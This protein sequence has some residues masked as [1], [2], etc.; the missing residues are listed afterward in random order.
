MELPGRLVLLGHPVAQSLSPTFQN[1]ALERAGIALVYEA[2]DVAPAELPQ[3]LGLLR[4]A[5]GAGNVTVPHKQAVAAQCARRSPV[6][7]RAGA[8]N[9]FWTE[10]GELIGDNTDVG[11]FDR[12][13]RET[14]GRP[15]DGTHLL[16]LGAG[17]AASAVLTAAERWGGARVTVLSRSHERTA[18]LAARFGR[19]VTP[20]R[21]LDA[22]LLQGVDLVVNATP[23]GIEGDAIPLD[24]A[25]LPAH[26][27]VYDLTYR[28]GKTPWV[29]ACRARGLKAD[30][31]LSMLL[32]QGALAF[33]R[34]FGIVPDRAAMKDALTERVRG[35]RG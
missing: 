4:E 14:F 23:I 6:A 15:K 19:T 12:A 17:G 33:E 22:E 13:I 3:L 16:L 31:G 35:H 21:S 11:G 20:V 2:V 28:R 34:W 8:V 9:T 7:E 25:V 10:D 24:P 1:A 30:D 32:E 27:M 18:S 29:Q 26:A 5:G